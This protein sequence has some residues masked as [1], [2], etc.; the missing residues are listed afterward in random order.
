MSTFLQTVLK[1]AVNFYKFINRLSSVPGAVELASVMWLPF[2]GIFPA[3]ITSGAIGTAGD[4]VGLGSVIFGGGATLAIVAAEFDFS[5]SKGLLIVGVIGIGLVIG[6]TISAIIAPVIEP[7]LW[8]TVLQTLTALV[9]GFITLKIVYPNTPSWVPSIV[10]IGKLLLVVM[11]LNILFGFLTGG[12]SPMSV[13]S[14]VTELSSAD[15]RLIGHSILAGLSGLTI[16]VL[17]VVF[18]PY[19]VS[20][21]VIRRFKFGCALALCTVVAEL[22]ALIESAPVF[23]LLVCSFFLALDPA[24]TNMEAAH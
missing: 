12:L 21:V 9:I 17:A 22:I 8:M 16:A 1:S 11:S 20:L 6:T 13:F 3:L 7:V 15:Y 10:A 18:R 24:E 2:I 4:A 23:F 19:V 14:Q 5:R